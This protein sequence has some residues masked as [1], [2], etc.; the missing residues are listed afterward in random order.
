MRLAKPQR[1]LVVTAMM[2]NCTRQR[3]YQLFQEVIV[4]N[5]YFRKTMLELGIIIAII[6][7][8]DT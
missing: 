8:F 4:T 7:C 5:Q 1:Y 3:R 2:K 6:V